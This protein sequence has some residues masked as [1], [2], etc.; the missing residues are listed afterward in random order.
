MTGSNPTTE[1]A[2]IC[3]FDQIKDYKPRG[4][5]TVSTYN[6][7][8]KI[9]IPFSSV[10]IKGLLDITEQEN[11]DGEMRKIFDAQ[12]IKSLGTPRWY[13][14]DG[15]SNTEKQ[16]DIFSETLSDKPLVVGL[17][18]FRENNLIKGFDRIF[19]IQSNDRKAEGK[20]SVVQNVAN[21]QEYNFTVSDLTVNQADILSIDWK[22]NDSVVICAESRS[23]TCAYTFTSFGNFKIDAVVNLIGNKTMT[24]SERVQIDQPLNIER[25]VK[26]NNRSGKVLNPQET[27]DMRTQTFIIKD[28]VPPDT[29]VFDARDVISSNPGY[30]LK[31]VTWNINDGHSTETRTGD[32]ID[33]PINRTA[34]YT[35]TA[36]YTFEKSIKTGQADDTRKA[37]DKI[38]LD[39]E[40]KNLTPILKISQTSDYVPARV[41]V[42]ASQSMAEYSEIIK[43]IFDF[44]E[45]RPPA[46]GDAIQTY[47]YTTPGQKTITVTAVDSHGEKATTK[48]TVVLKETPRTLNFTTSLSPGIVNQTVDFRAEG[49]SGQVEDYLWNFGDNT[50]ISHGYEA[51]HT[52]SRSGEYTVTL[53]VRYTDGTERSTLQKFSVVNSLE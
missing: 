41:T 44:G 6:K 18:V 52:F 17:K 53:T 45:G 24:I 49:T 46:E 30:V 10:E 11:K 25:H 22:L 28:I 34:R 2:I 13:Y 27:Y 20:I 14:L 50:P 16:T 38:M 35:I 15:S 31:G 12:R 7:E 33:F 37:L 36:E 43:F 42:D 21:P 39:L 47:Q 5:Y 8:E 3:T 23:S 51:S 9:Q 40:R 4:E 32:K 26:I 48:E 1:E 29:I 19:I